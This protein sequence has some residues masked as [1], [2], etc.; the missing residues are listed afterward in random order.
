M[1]DGQQLQEEE[2]DEEEEEAVAELLAQTDEWGLR[3]LHYAAAEGQVRKEIRG[4][5]LYGVVL[6]CV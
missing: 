5:S 1:L 3:P 4:S 2:E 6:W